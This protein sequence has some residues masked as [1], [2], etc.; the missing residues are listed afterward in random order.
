MG[1]YPGLTSHGQQGSPKAWPSG[2]WG[3]WEDGA[4][5]LTACAVMGPLV[6]RQPALGLQSSV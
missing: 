2:R 1:W 6:D 4:V 5:G 3:I